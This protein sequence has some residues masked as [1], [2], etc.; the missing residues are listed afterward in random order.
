MGNRGSI[1]IFCCIMMIALLTLGISVLTAVEYHMAQAKGA[2]AVRSAM[3]GV[4]AGYNSY[5]FEKYHILLFDKN[6]NGK[7]EAYLEEQLLADISHNLGGDFVV[8]DVAVSDYCMLMDE[9]CSEFKNQISDYCGYALLEYGGESILEATGG[10][11]G[12]VADYILEDM[13]AAKQEEE[14]SLNMPG[15]EYEDPRDYTEGLTADGILAIVAPEDLKIS[16]QRVDLSGVPSIEKVSFAWFDF[17]VDNDFDDIDRL[18]QDIGAYDSWKDKVAQGGAGIVYASK[19]FNCATDVVQEDTVFDFEIEY[20]ICRKSTDR[21]NLKGVVNRIIGVRLPVNYTY[22]ISDVKR[23]SEVKKLSWPIALATLVPEPVVRYLIAGCWA[24]VESIFDVKLLL[25]GHQMDF[26]KTN[27]NWMTDLCDLGK[28]VKISEGK[29][30]GGMD[31]KDYLMIL[32]ALNM[33]DGYYRMLDII[34]L[35]TKQK[36]PDF[37]MDRAAVGFGLDAHISYD[38]KDNYYRETIGY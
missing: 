20:L 9:E 16:N 23:M 36:Y 35:N 14:V 15:K 18:E 3:S 10:Q 27:N 17:E 6:Y 4:D 11:D 38:G 12:T 21:D 8:E 24:Y 25:E 32:L 5:I 26:L 28:S 2:V 33:Q 31:Y 34:E 13:E 19:V 22:L 30:E 37:D 7:G 29:S 1:T